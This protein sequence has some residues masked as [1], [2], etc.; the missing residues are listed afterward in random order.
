MFLVAE[1]AY[2]TGEVIMPL[3]NNLTAAED[4]RRLQVNDTT[5]LLPHPQ[6]W[7][8]CDPNSII[9]WQNLNLTAKRSIQ[10]HEQVTY[11]YGTSE[12]DYKIGEFEC[13]CQAPT[14]VGIFKGFRYMRSAQQRELLP[15]VSPYILQKWR[16]LKGSNK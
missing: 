1:R 10:L 14:C 16:R 4:P 12:W 13:T 3:G 6:L 9:D 11:H 7:H 8:S 15:F 2:M 5:F